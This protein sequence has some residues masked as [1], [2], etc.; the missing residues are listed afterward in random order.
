MR[1]KIS[2]NMKLYLVCR[3]NVLLRDKNS[4]CELQF[5]GED[6]AVCNNISLSA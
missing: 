6:T 4:D 2:F 5:R 1:V 3:D